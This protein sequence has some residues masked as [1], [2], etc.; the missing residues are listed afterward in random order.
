MRIPETHFF[1]EIECGGSSLQAQLREQIVAADPAAPLSARRAFAGD[2]TAC[3]GICRV[4]RVT[5]NLA[6]QAL[7]ADGYLESRPRSGV[8]VSDDPRRVSTSTASLNNRF[9]AARR[10]QAKK[11]ERKRR[12]VRLDWRDRLGLDRKSPVAA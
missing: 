6:Y 5:V 8:Y 3:D 10:R 7:E 4:A 12:D 11:P 9:G 2:A 1:I